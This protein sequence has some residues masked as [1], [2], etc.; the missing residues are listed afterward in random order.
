MVRQRLVGHVKFGADIRDAWRSSQGIIPELTCLLDKAQTNI[1]TEL[2]ELA[3]PAGQR[4]G[5]RAA[6]DGERGIFSCRKKVCLGSELV[7]FDLLSF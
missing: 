7:D 6:I 2:L 4:G 1:L 3:I 5:H